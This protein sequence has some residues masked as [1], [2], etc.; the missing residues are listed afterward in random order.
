M[1][2]AMVAATNTICP[3][4]EERLTAVLDFD[5]TAAERTALVDYDDGFRLGRDRGEADGARGIWAFA[6]PRDPDV[7]PA[8]LAGYSDGY[9]EGYDSG[10][11]SY[12]EVSLE[13]W[14][15][16]YR[17]GLEA[18]LNAF[19][20]ADPNRIAPTAAEIRTRVS[21][22]MTTAGCPRNTLP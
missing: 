17:L 20:A 21:D 19:V 10:I 9:R 14:C 2:G 3:W 8:Y 4:N 16:G 12:D 1:V 18:N 13:R 22:P 6:D 15:L 7:T 5:G 11:E